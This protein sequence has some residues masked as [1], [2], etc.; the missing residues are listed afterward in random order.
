MN[1]SSLQEFRQF[2]ASAEAIMS[3]RHAAS[4]ASP[5]STQDTKRF[6]D[7]VADSERLL[8]NQFHDRLPLI[9]GSLR[10]LVPWIT[11][12]DLLAIAN[13]SLVEDSYTELLAWMI[14]EETHP[15]TAIVRQQAVID[16]MK[17]DYRVTAPCIPHTQFR[18]DDGRP[19]LVLL[20]PDAYFTIEVKTTSIEH[21]TPSGEFQTDSYP[22]AVRS[23]AKLK[24]EIPDHAGYLTVD[25][26][27]AQNEKAHCF[28]FVDIVLALAH[29]LADADLD[30]HTRTGFAQVLT[31]WLGHA[32]PGG[33]DA[34]KLVLQLDAMLDQDP[35]QD[36]T[37]LSALKQLMQFSILFRLE[38][39]H[40]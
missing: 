9:R 22:P 3:Q 30:P 10:I 32:M 23:K 33:C 8:I 15:A 16:A 18:T 38:L 26:S 14:R 1:A 12:H 21:L 29:A 37:F 27:P 5:V 34:V 7:F 31:H 11:R 20:F 13:L 19:D 4:F 28:A 6:L 25:R 17:V 24:D 36:A 40:A 39:S 2:I 35:L